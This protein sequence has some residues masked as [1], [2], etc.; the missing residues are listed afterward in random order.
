MKGLG[1]PG[2]ST[3]L[4]KNNFY[5][6]IFGDD[7]GGDVFASSQTL[8]CEKHHG[9][10]RLFLEL[11]RSNTFTS[12]FRQEVETTRNGSQ[13]KSGSHKSGNFSILKLVRNMNFQVGKDTIGSRTG[14]ANNFKRNESYKESNTMINFHL[15]N[16]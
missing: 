14:F 2:D 1:T 5:Q 4:S 3:S 11:V 6:E 9:C 8:K 12:T 10:R 15:N 16:N 7:F 13:S